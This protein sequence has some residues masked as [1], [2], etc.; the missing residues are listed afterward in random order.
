MGQRHVAGLQPVDG[1]N[2]SS[3]ATGLRRGLPLARRIGAVYD[4]FWRG[5]PQTAKLRLDFKDASLTAQHLEKPAE[6]SAIQLH[7]SHS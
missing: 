7:L 5:R 2:G 1:E 4:E 3:E 6:R